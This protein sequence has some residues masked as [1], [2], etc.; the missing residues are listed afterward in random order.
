MKPFHKFDYY[1]AY[2]LQ[3]NMIGRADHNGPQGNGINKDKS[4][5]LSVTDNHAIAYFNYAHSESTPSQGEIA[6][7]QTARQHKQIPN[8][9]IVRKIITDIPFTPKGFAGYEE[10]F[11]TLK[12]S[13][14][15]LGGGSES[16]ITHT[17]EVLPDFMYIVRRL[18]PVEC[19]RLQGFPDNWTKFGAN[20]EKEIADTPRYQM[21]GNSVAIPCVRFILGNIVRAETRSR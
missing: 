13:G 14:G 19:E 21:L 1:M 12:T 11:G 3:G 16:I 4:F 5:T 17:I 15:D 6:S 10:G 2:A 20:G 9:L 8:D 7:C 18:T